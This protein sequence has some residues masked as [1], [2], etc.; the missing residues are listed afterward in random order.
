MLKLEKGTDASRLLVRWRTKDPFFEPRL[1][2]AL[3]I[4]LFLH[5]SALFFF[6]VAP[7][8]TSSQF[9]FTPLKV[10]SQ[11]PAKTSLTLTTVNQEDSFAPPLS[12]IPPLDWISPLF[13]S[14]SLSQVALTMDPF[15][16]L[17]NLIWPTWHE[18]LP[19]PIE[20][21]FI[22]LTISGALAKRPLIKK[23]PLLDEKRSYFLDEMNPRHL[24]YQVQVDPKKGEIF[25]YERTESSGIQAIDGLAESILLN[26]RFAVDGSW[27]ATKGT[28]TFLINEMK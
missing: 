9:L 13:D 20:E 27:E 21:P 2:K 7:F 18:P 5:L 26:L 24:S 15:E 12:L 11:L 3:L 28:L 23:D 4:A 16:S 25:W 6:H 19:F 8:K 17:E 10:H 14:T 22:Q 1:I